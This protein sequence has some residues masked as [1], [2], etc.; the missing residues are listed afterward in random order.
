MS[1]DQK[2]KLKSFMVMACATNQDCANALG[3]HLATFS[4]KLNG[5]TDWTLDE[6]KKLC[7]YLSIIDP[8][9]MANIFI[10]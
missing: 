3:I 6:V 5:K 10:W 8:S 1:A 7:K 9:D 2:K 4:N